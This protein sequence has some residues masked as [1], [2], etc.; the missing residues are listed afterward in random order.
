MSWRYY[1]IE[2]HVS[3]P[4]GEIP[5]ELRDDYWQ[6]N[7]MCHILHDYGYKTMYEHPVSVAMAEF[8]KRIDEICDEDDG[9]EIELHKATKERIKQVLGAA[10]SLF[11]TSY[12][13]K[14]MRDLYTDPPGTYTDEVAKLFQ[15][16]DDAVGA[17]TDKQYVD[18]KKRFEKPCEVCLPFLAILNGTQ[19]P[20]TPAV[21][22]SIIDGIGDLTLIDLYRSSASDLDHDVTA[23]ILRAR[24]RGVLSS[25]SKFNAGTRI[26]ELKNDLACISGTCQYQK[27]GFCVADD[28]GG[29]SAMSGRV[30]FHSRGSRLVRVASAGMMRETVKSRF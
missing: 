5:Y 13:G 20:V 24:L 25:P 18:G 28:T 4:G 22:Q 14:R 2:D 15:A 10:A 19:K 27:D 17:D 3:H 6:V 26:I 16:I 8:S 12:S 29:C 30:L 11:D 21:M 9:S 23:A 7:L 1:Q